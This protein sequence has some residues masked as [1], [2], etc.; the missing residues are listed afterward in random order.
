M[1]KLSNPYALFEFRFL[2]MTIILLLF[3]FIDENVLSVPG[4][5]VGKKLGLDRD[6]CYDVK[7]HWI[8][9]YFL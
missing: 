5:K 1:D 8:S 2:K 9:S 6:L 4:V 7:N 3:I